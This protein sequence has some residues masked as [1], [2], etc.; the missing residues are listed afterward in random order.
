MSA[1]RVSAAVVIRVTDQRRNGDPRV[2]HVGPF[3]PH[4]G[5]AVNRALDDLDESAESIEGLI[6]RELA[7]VTTFLAAGESDLD[8]FK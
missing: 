3:M 6:S 4:A 7:V 1:D 2:W 8:G 5:S